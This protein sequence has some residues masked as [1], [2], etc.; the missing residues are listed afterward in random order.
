MFFIANNRT[1]TK[2]RGDSIRTK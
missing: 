1:S 2:Q